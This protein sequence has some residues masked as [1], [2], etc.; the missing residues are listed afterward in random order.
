MKRQIDREKELEEKAK[1]AEEDK[2]DNED[3]DDDLFVKLK[4]RQK[5]A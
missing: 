4:P 5:T 2:K 1:M 3:S